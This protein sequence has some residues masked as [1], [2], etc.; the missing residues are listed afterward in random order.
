[1][2]VPFMVAPAQQGYANIVTSIDTPS[3]TPSTPSVTPTI[4][5]IPMDKIRRLLFL[6]INKYIDLLALYDTN[7]I[8]V[9]Q[10]ESDMAIATGIFHRC[11]WFL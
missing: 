5:A 1:M 11:I 3:I 8:E 7:D 4:P 10:N 6:R 9:I 2:A